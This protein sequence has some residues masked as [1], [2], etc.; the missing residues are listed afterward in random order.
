[1]RQEGRWWV[2]YWNEW[3]VDPGSTEARW[4]KFRSPICPVKH[5]NGL[6]VTEKEARDIFEVMVLDKLAI[7]N[8]NPRM[9][10]TLDEF[11]RLKFLPKVDLKNKRKGKEH[12]RTMLK[13]I[14]PKLG[15]LQLRQITG[16][17]VQ[18]LI[19]EMAAKI[20][21]R[22]GKP[23]SPQTLL[24]VKNAISGIFNYAKRVGWF[25][26]DVPTLGVELPE[27]ERRERV[28]LSKDQFRRLLAALPDTARDMV[29]ILAFTGLRIGEM[30]GLRWKKVNLTDEPVVVDGKV[31]PPFSALIN[32]AYIRVAREQVEVEDPASGK[33]RKVP[34]N[35]D[36]PY[37]QYQTV[38]GRNREGRIIPLIE[39][40]VEA[41]RGVRQRSKFTGPEDPIFAGPTGRP[42]DDR[43]EL[44]RRIKPAL[45][46]L[47]LPNLSWH[48]LRHTANAWAESAGMTLT[49]RK[50]L[51]GWKKNEM[52]EI[53]GHADVEAMREGLQK[54]VKGMEIREAKVI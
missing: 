32:E 45:R 43:N 17:H 20:N 52:A 21:P 7:V 25:H 36:E 28:A 54:A 6:E 2:G 27:M 49:E 26:G 41:L 46:K 5:P 30:L 9:L 51:F 50:R 13:H 38:K 44:R 47:G 34:K 1:M 18:D 23:Y 24:H 42:I 14:L 40:V 19:Q 16:D 31:L 48:D 12:Y 53:Y 37:G 33:K 39:P 4:K 3:I 8:R 35:P 11:V 15:K 22:S 29:L 10:A